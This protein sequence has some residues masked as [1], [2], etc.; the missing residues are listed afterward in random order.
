MKINNK[1][2]RD[3]IPQIIE[4]NNSIPITRILSNEEYLSELDKKLKEELDEYLA[5]GNVE[6]LADMMEVM[7]GILTAKGVQYDEFEKIRIDKVLER[8][9]FEQR[10][11]LEKVLEKDE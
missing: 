3:K 11:F 2:V 5:D 8:G 7:L 9:A 10:I 1:L 6:E 4:G